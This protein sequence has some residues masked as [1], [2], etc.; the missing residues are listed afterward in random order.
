MAT[1]NFS[2]LRCI[3]INNFSNIA[4]S[5]DELISPA[6]NLTGAPTATL[7]FKLHYAAKTATS[8][9]KLVI[10]TSTNCGQT[11]ALKYIKNGTTSLKTVATYYTSSHTPPSGSSEWRQES[12]NLTNNW[13]VNPVRFKFTF[14][15]GGGNNIFIDDININTPLTTN[16]KTWNEKSGISIFPNPSENELNLAFESKINNPFEIEFI[17][18]LGKLIFT[19]HF[20]QITDQKL[21]IDTKQLS[22]GVYFINIKTNNAV[23]YTDKFIKQYS[24]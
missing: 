4:P 19:Q 10:Y 7:N 20:N 3:G 15:S 22:E 11:W 9:D 2:G 16:V 6:Y 12:I 14:T 5:V 1:T 24:K 17:D 13:G 21:K 18:V 23:I 8:Y